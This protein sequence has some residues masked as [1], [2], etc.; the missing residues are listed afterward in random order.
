MA[1]WTSWSPRLPSFAV[2]PRPLR[3]SNLPE[4]DPLGMVTM[5]RP[6]VAL[7]RRYQKDALRIETS[8]DR[9]SHADIAYQ[10]VA[11]SP[12]DIEHAQR[13]GV[14]RSPGPAIGDGLGP[15]LV[16]RRFRLVDGKVRP[17][18][19]VGAFGHQRIEN[20]T[21]PLEIAELDID[22]VGRAVACQARRTILVVLIFGIEADR[23]GLDILVLDACPPERRA[24]TFHLCGILFDR[25]GGGRLQRLYAS[26]NDREIRNTGH[27]PS[28]ADIQPGTGEHGDGGHGLLGH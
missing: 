21:R 25:G 2:N 17:I 12:T 19:G 20:R 26:R 6:I 16:K 7:A 1:S 24:N 15:S 28:R 18:D 14:E 9:E 27:L 4:L 8:G 3:R 11:V 22:R 10:A 23:R 5:P 13:P